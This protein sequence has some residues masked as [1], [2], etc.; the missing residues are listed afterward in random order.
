MDGRQ[1]ICLALFS[2]Y[3][4]LGADDLVFAFE[5]SQDETLMGAIGYL[6]DVGLIERYGRYFQLPTYLMDAV[7]RRKQSD[8][9]LAAL[10]TIRRRFIE[11]L[12][13]FGGDDVI[14][15][16]TIE[17][18]IVAALRANQDLPQL[19]LRQSLLPSQLLKVA[20]E[21]YDA[22][23]YAR[24]EEL[25]GRAL[26]RR[27]GLTREAHIEA[28]RIRGLA[29][30]RRNKPDTF[31]ECLQDLEKYPELVA[32]RIANFLQGFK[33][34]WEGRPDAAEQF[35]RRAHEFGGDQNFHVL[36]ELAQVLIYQG[37]YGE[38]EKFARDALKVG[39][40]N[41]NPYVLDNLLEILI[42]TRKTDAQRLSEDPEIRSLFD[43]LEVS[44]KAARRSF[45]ES[46]QSHYYLALRNFP[47]ALEWADKAI[48]ATPA[49]VPV[50][51]NRADIKFA[52]HDHQGV[53][54]DIEKIDGL[55]KG[56]SGGDKRHW[57]Q[58][59]KLKI[60]LLIEQRSYAAA[61]LALQST[62]GMPARLRAALERDL[63][64]EVLADSTT[65]PELRKWANQRLTALGAA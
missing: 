40:G 19:W 64:H 5:D 14:P 53:R 10:K 7:S 20:R 18:G 61:R 44:A 39:G 63:A 4:C 48:T 37:R 52:L 26:E 51:V 12:A 28:L 57:H 1:E 11:R 24:A 62:A 15:I 47:L 27:G 54:R 16:S 41:S 55:L 36:R 43:R 46:R 34:R 9:T 2:E 17:S 60:R 8:D 38:A 45:F 49:F 23:E 65:E 3:G 42:E 6:Q 32:K 35:F 13:L 22:G 29:S 21:F 33:K 25:C 58:L 31:S 56:K 50:Y 30:V 59:E